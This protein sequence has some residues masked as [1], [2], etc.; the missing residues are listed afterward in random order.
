VDRAEI[1][2]SPLPAAVAN[3]AKFF[4]QQFL[5]HQNGCAYDNLEQQF[6]RF[7]G[8]SVAS[9]IIGSQVLFSDGGV[10]PFDHINMNG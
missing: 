4:L 3:Q 9:P 2:S 5:A 7:C 1:G 10:G 8:G 6:L